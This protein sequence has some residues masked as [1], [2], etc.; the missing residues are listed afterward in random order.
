MIPALERG[1]R[2]RKVIPYVAI[3]TRIYALP[4]I[5]KPTLV[6]LPTVSNIGLTF[7]F[8]FFHNPCLT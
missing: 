2:K 1:G 8:V 6:F 5:H 4:K 3:C 7:L